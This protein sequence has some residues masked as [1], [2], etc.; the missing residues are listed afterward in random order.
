MQITMHD[1]LPNGDISFLIASTRWEAV[2]DHLISKG[3]NPSGHYNSDAD[4]SDVTV[5]CTIQ[6]LNEALQDFDE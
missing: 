2:I 4:I 6:S 1:T 5:S 3:I